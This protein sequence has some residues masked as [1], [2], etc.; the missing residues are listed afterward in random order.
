MGTCKN[1]LRHFFFSS[2]SRH[3][4]GHKKKSIAVELTGVLSFF[5]FSFFFF[6]FF[7]FLQMKH[8]NET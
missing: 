6:F 3:F 7:F 2:E 4:Y 8:A 5:F 1:N